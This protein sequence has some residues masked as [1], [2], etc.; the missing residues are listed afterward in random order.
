MSDV[1]S[2]D[3]CSSMSDSQVHDMGEEGIG[4][5]ETHKSEFVIKI[6]NEESVNISDSELDESVNTAIN[7]ISR[8]RLTQGWERSWTGENY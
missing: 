8:S 3:H 7:L 6:G 4:I 2:S 5:N 1:T